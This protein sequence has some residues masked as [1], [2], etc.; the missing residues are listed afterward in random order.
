MKKNLF[1]IT[2]LFLGAT[3]ITKAQPTITA[4]NMPQI[5]DVVTIAICSD[6]PDSDALGMAIGENI[7]WDF[8]NLT[9]SEEQ[10]F[11][12]VASEDTDFGED[13]PESNI[14]G[15]SWQGNLTF[16]NTEGNELTTEGYTAV[17]DGMPLAQI[18]CT[19]LEKIVSI[20]YTYETSFS[21]EFS[22]TGNAAG[23]GFTYSGSV[24]FI[25]DGYGTLELPNGTYENVVR[26]R[27]DRTETA[28][29]IGLP[30][31]VTVSKTQ[32]AWVSADHRFWL[33]LMEEV[34]DGTSTSTLVWYDKTPLGIVTGVTDSY[35]PNWEMYPNPV[36]AGQ[37][38]QLRDAE[39]ERGFHAEMID[40]S[41][42][43]VRVYSENQRLLNTEGINSG[44]YILNLASRNGAFISAQKLIIE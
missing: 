44:T 16:Y 7:T 17:L 19:D 13:Y 9:E 40:L 41:G 21:D 12:F 8:S 33:L 42:K 6:I 36:S 23:N 27:I 31:G 5:G 28:T 35:T 4:N 15:I 11:N 18:I 25:A 24:D 29:L 20:P 1:F 14:C 38:I 2:T 32:W 22:G 37:N 39:L 10:F 34:F 26:Y 30:G 43:I 3:T